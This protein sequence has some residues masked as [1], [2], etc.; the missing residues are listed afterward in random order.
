VKG[1]LHTST[2]KKHKVTISTRT[3]KDDDSK[4]TRVETLLKSNIKSQEL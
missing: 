4:L 2:G 3:Q 1:W